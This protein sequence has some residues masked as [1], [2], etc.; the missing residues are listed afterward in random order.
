MGSEHLKLVLTP[1]RLILAHLGKRG[2]GAIAGTSL[3]GRL[4]T[5]LED[6]FKSPRE[7]SRRRKMEEMRPEEILKLDKDN[8]DIN[9]QEIIRIE[10]EPYPTTIMILTRDN[11][12]NFT[13]VTEY[14]AAAQ[15][16]H[17]A[18]GTRLTLKG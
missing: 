18:V 7:S 9:Y 13:S 17:H 1:T 3:L 10:L 6:L 16:L 15:I 14:E 8:F 5:G 2:A 4:S 12:Y 11:K